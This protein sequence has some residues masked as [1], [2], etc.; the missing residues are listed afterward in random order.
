MLQRQRGRPKAEELAGIEARLIDV[1]KALFFENGYGHT[2]MSAV[3]SAARVSKTTLYSRFPSKA[4][5]FKAMVASQTADW[6]NGPRSTR[7]DPDADLRD[8]LL[9]YGAIAVRAGMSADFI[10][11]N[12]LLFSESGRFP[13]LGQI[14]EVRLDLGLG[15][16]TREIRSQALREGLDV[17]NPAE[18][19]QLFLAILNGWLATAILTNH[20][21]DQDQR[22]AWICKAV[23]TALTAP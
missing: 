22:D 15:Y 10:N 6:G 23:N 13:E 3:A 18:T 20:L 16:L 14:A 5:L 2:T 7:I 12:R 21:P 11:I 8:F 1:A 9:A 4:E 17:A 19:A